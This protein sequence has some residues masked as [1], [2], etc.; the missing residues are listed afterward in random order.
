MKK[1]CLVMVF[2]TV[3]G[4]SVHSWE[5]IR[6]FW[7]FGDIG[8]SWEN[9]TRDHYISPVLNAGN[10]AWITRPGLGWGFHLFNIESSRK[11]VNMMILPLEVNYSPIGFSGK[12]L[13]LTMYGRGGWMVELEKNSP[14]SFADRNGFLGAAGLRVA[15]NPTL[16]KN[17][18][19]YAGGFVEYNTRNQLRVGVSV[20]L[21]IFALFWLYASVKS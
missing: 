20:D 8:I 4:A 9:L 15:W 13:M 11:W 18:A 16:G 17:W 1:A 7:S 10:I 19:L 6:M 5:N 12:G 14:R 21:S 2:L 3:F